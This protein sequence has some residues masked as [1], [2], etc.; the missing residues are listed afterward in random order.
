MIAFDTNV[1]TGIL[2]GDETFLAKASAIPAH[3]QS[4]P[5]IV[6]EEIIRGRLT[7][8]RQAEAGK[9]KV[10]LERAYQ[11]FQDTFTDARRLQIRALQELPETPQHLVISNSEEFEAFKVEPDSLKQMR[12]ICDSI[13]TPF[14]D[15]DLVVQALL[16][17]ARLAVEK[18]IGDLIEPVI[19]RC[20]KGF[21]AFQSTLLHSSDPVGDGARGRFFALL[22]VKDCAQLF[23]QVIGLAQV[24]RAFQQ[25][26]DGLRLLRLKIG[27]IPAKR[28]HRAFEQ[29]VFFCIEA[30]LQFVQL[31]F[32][33]LVGALAVRLRDM[34][35]INHHLG[36]CDLFFDRVRVA[37][38]HVGAD[39]LNTRPQ[40]E[41]DR[42]Q[43]GHDRLFLAIGE[44]AEQCQV[45]VLLPQGDDHDEIAVAFA[46]GDLI[47]P[48][49]FQGRELP[50]VDRARHASIDRAQDCVIT[51]LLLARHV[52][53]RAVDQ[54]PE[55][56]LI[57]GFGVRRARLVPIA[58][59]RG[60]RMIVASR[61]AITLRAQFDEYALFQNRQMSQADRVI[62]AVKFKGLLSTAGADPIGARAFDRDDDL[63]L[64]QFSFQNADFRQVQRKLDHWRH[65]SVPFKRGLVRPQPATTSTTLQDHKILG[66]IRQ[67]PESP[68]CVGGRKSLPPGWAKP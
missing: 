66:F 60:R 36:L 45:T 27:G 47:H 40:F 51:D 52:A 46:Q 56:R 61:A 20:Q 31:T 3:E 63:S 38:V 5:V 13:T 30:L 62:V 39:A 22:S 17:A 55:Q 25:Q 29:F 21:K 23:A 64:F 41:R 33:Q 11:L 16:K 2:L 65:R 43:E 12:N 14:E 7:I 57:K 18:V 10:T 8:I 44:H 4:V 1:L 32:A 54:L 68:I 48:D 50:P 53:D 19:E 37:F 49:D 34:K 42:M 24:R 59:L 6:I 15:F 67:F 9:A 58:L 35:T 26:R 28:P